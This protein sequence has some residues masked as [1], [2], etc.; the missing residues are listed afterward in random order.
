LSDKLREIFDVF[1]QVAQVAPHGEHGLGLGADFG[2]ATMS[3]YMAAACKRKALERT[4]AANSR[5]GFR[6][7]KAREPSM[8]TGER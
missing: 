6:Y 1:T 5:C 7:C 2:N 8:D 4:K 3:T